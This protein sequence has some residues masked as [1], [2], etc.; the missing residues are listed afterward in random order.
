[1]LV[2]DLDRKDHFLEVDLDDPFFR[3]FSVVTTAPFDF[4]R[5]GLASASVAMDYGDTRKPETSK[6]TDISFEHE[7]ATGKTWQVFMTNLETSYRNAV[8]Y[9]F[10]PDSDWQGESFEYELPPEETE[11][12]RLV[13]NPYKHLGF[14]D[15]TV[16]PNR[17]D[18]GVIDS[19][20]VHLSYESPTG[21][22]HEQV[23]NV[24]PGSAPQHVRLRVS[25]PDERGAR[26][27]SYRL[28]HHLRDGTTKELGPRTQEAT[29]IP[30][31][32]PFEGA[33]DLEL[34]PLYRAG[35]FRTVYVDLEYDDP[36][37]EYK[38]RERL[39]LDGDLVDPVSEHLS[40]MDPKKRGFRY[41]VTYV[42]SDNSL[43]RGS[44]VDTEETL[45][46]LKPDF[47]PAPGNQPGPTPTPTPRPTPTPGTPGGTPGLPGATPFGEGESRPDPPPR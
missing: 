19:T 40:L 43:Q 18:A 21:W 37:N 30:V 44:S 23:L 3:D 28:V 29:S 45:L 15:I 17:M 5:I 22:S 2:E 39:E 24:E 38:R 32:D 33:L 20:D 27:Y 4:A 46:G 26:T 12:R 10:D 8:T 36:E 25:K 9:Q 35:A 41:R 7:D 47:E 1:L 13:L 14:L 6:H 34:I 31:D 11:E 16:R 42:G